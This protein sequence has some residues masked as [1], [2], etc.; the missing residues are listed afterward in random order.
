MAKD[1]IYLIVR[2]LKNQDGTNK[3]HSIGIF[4]SNLEIG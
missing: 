1:D 2:S 4:W 3:G